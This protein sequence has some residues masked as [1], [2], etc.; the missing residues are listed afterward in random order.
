MEKAGLVAARELSRLVRDNQAWAQVVRL[1]RFKDLLLTDEHRLYNP[2]DAQD[3]MVLGIQGAFNEFE[4]DMILDRGQECVREK[5][6]R[7]EQYDALPA[8][9]NPQRKRVLAPNACVF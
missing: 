3:R 7:G 2:S 8:G 5:A 9:Y 1:C 6:K 4:R